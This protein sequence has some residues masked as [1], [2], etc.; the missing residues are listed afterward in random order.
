MLSSATAILEACIHEVVGWMNRMGLKLNKEK[1]EFFY[2]SSPWNSR[3]IPAD[4]IHTR[5]R[6][7]D[8]PVRNL[9]VYFDTQISMSEQVTSVCK[10]HLTTF[11]TFEGS[12][13]ILTLNLAGCLRVL[14]F[15]HF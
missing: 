14:W 3:I 2:L 9:G 11:L 13:H 10:R 7:F 8:K 4:E 6:Q 1:T 5:F 15:C 12:C